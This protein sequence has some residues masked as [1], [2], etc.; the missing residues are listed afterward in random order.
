[1]RPGTDQMNAREVWRGERR[2]LIRTGCDQLGSVGFSFADQA[3]HVDGEAGGPKPLQLVDALGQ[4]GHR[5]PPVA[6]APVIEA[7]SHQQDALIQV[8]DRVWL[9]DPDRFQRLVAL[10]VQ[11]LVEL[12]DA[13]EEGRRRRLVAPGGGPGACLAQMRGD[14]GLPGRGLVVREGGSG[15]P[16]VG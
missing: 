6:A 2:Q 13:L 15:G 9:R 12:V 8:A 16:T 14:G 5:A 10:E 11:L 4:L 3:V 1:M 7:D